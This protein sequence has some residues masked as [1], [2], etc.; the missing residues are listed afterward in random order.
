MSPAT[1]GWYYAKRVQRVRSS[2]E[3]IQRR[4]HAGEPLETELSSEY[5]DAEALIISLPLQHTKWHQAAGH[6]MLLS[7]VR[8]RLTARQAQLILADPDTLRDLGWD[9]RQSAHLRGG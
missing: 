2:L 5:I 9:A 3:P 6:M 1:A 7:P 8:A 4:D